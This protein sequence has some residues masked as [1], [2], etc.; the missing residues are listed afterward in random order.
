MPCTEL[1]HRDNSLG[2]SAPDVNTRKISK[3]QRYPGRQLKIS[4]RWQTEVDNNIKIN[5]YVKFLLI[6]QLF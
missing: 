4:I 1:G 2:L 5:Y 6:A 3:M